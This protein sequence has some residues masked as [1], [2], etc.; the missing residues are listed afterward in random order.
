V[1]HIYTLRI[2]ASSINLQAKYINK[3]SIYHG[4]DRP[5]EDIRLVRACVRCTVVEE[6]AA[7]PCIAAD[8]IGI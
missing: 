2:S 7:T 1:K 8:T 6:H 4:A 3:R 5:D